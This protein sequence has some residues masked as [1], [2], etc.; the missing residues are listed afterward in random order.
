M[1]YLISDLSKIR[2]INMRMSAPFEVIFEDAKNTKHLALHLESANEIT[3]AANDT[4]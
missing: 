1:I 4:I 3:E 2:L